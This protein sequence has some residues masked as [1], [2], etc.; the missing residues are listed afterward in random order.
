MSGASRNE[1]PRR[2]ASKNRGRLEDPELHVLDLAVAKA[3][4]HRALALDAREVVGPDRSPL[5]HACRCLPERGR[6]RV[7]RAEDALDAAVGDAEHLELPR[8][9]NGVRAP[10]SARSSRSSR[11]CTSGRAPR[12]RRASPA[13]GTVSRARPSRRRCRG[14]CTR[15]RRS[16]TRSPAG[17]RAGTRSA[18]RAAGACRSDSRA[19]RSRRARARRSAS[20]SRASRCTR[21]MRRRRA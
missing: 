17:V 14:A 2:S 9:R 18:P 1:R 6:V 13:R 8:Q 7:E 5:S 4:R 21:A 19:A 16:R 12:T 11:G 20:R 15:C 10:P 3:N